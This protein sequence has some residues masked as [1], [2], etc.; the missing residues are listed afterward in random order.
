MVDIRS[1]EELH[2][3][4][5]DLSGT[6]NLRADLS[7][8]SP[9]YSTY[10]GPS[11]NGGL[12]WEPI[13]SGMVGF[14]GVFNGNGHTI[15]DIVIKRNFGV[16]LF[17]YIF[18]GGLVR[19]L[20]IINPQIYY[21]GTDM[22]NVGALAGSITT[23]ST[24]RQCYVSGGFVNGYK[25]VGALIGAVGTTTVEECYSYNVQ[26]QSTGPGA[27]NVGGLIGTTEY[28]GV[29]RD[30]YAEGGIVV[31]PDYTGGFIGHVNNGDIDRCYAAVNVSGVIPNVGG[32]IG[33]V[34]VG[35][36]DDCFYD[37]EISGQS[38]TGK[39][40]P[41]TTVEMMTLATFTNWDIVIIQNWAS[42]VWAINQG[43]NYP[44]LGWQVQELPAVVEKARDAVYI[45]IQL[46]KGIPYTN[47]LVRGAWDV[48]EDISTP[49]ITV[50]HTNQVATPIAA[51]GMQDQVVETLQIDCFGASEAQANQLKYAV[52]NIIIDNRRHP[53]QGLPDG[54]IFCLLLP[55]QWINNDVLNQAEGIYRRTTN[56][57]FTRFRGA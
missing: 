55:G 34:T 22:Y 24:V 14:S 32:F 49:S 45:A 18:N 47:I 40:T 35:D 23:G 11:A 6:Y 31:G 26:V 4:R 29:V 20:G 51:P 48:D 30:S 42:E 41:K 25:S 8:S 53:G 33:G 52:E 5:N 19:N 36:I 17:K 54:S 3:V 28:G 57:T 2:N 16:G 10:A 38:D 43:Y 13:E 50:Y 1:W 37:A 46:L 15:S 27:M 9:G 21:L 56:I 39:G 7:A 12:G 44:V